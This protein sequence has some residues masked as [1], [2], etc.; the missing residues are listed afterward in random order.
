M[1]SSSQYLISYDEDA[2]EHYCPIHNKDHTGSKTPHPQTFYNEKLMS[3]IRTLITGIGNS[4]KNET[5]DNY[6]PGEKVVISNVHF[7]HKNY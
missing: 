3:I 1:G 5:A 4:H 6:L 2:Y 7:R